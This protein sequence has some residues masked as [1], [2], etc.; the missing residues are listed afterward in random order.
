MRTEI[1]KIVRANDRIVASK[2]PDIYLRY[3]YGFTYILFSFLPLTVFVEMKVMFV[4]NFKNRSF[5]DGETR[6]GVKVLSYRWHLHLTFIDYGRPFDG[7]FLNDC[8]V[9]TRLKCFK[10]LY[11]CGIYN[12]LLCR[13]KDVRIGEPSVIVDGSPETITPQTCRLSDQT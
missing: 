2:Y 9:Y 13:F 12:V 1:K 11:W 3:T 5:Q 10:L 7:Q 8:L 6:T 4:Y